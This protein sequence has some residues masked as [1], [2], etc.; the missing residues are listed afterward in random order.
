MSSQY[1]QRLATL[2]QPKIQ[3]TLADIGRGIEKECLRVTP[4]GRLSERP[5]PLELGAALTHEAITTDYSEAL[6]EFI[7]PVYH[8]VDSALA[9][10]ERLHQYTYQVL[11]EEGE[12]LWVASMPCVL[13]GDDSI[14]IGQ[15]GSSNN[16]KMK[17]VYRQGLAHRYGKAMQ[18]IAGIHYNFS[19]PDSF[20]LA[21]QEAEGDKRTLQAFKDANYLRIIRNFHRY[22]WLL[23]YLFGAS[24]ALCKS[25]VGGVAGSL[26]E[27]NQGTFYAPFG[28]SLRM[29]D[30]GYQSSAQEDLTVSYNT[31]EDYIRPLHQALTTPHLEYQAIGVVGDDGEYRQLSTHLLQIENEFYSSIRPKRVTK[32]GE[33]PIN[34]LYERGIEYIEVRCLDLDP[35]SP[36]GMDSAQL[37]FIDQ[38]LLACLLGSDAEMS[39][40]EFHTSAANLK[41]VVNE[42]RRPGLQLNF[43][44]ECKVLTDWGLEMLDKMAGIAEQFDQVFDGDDYRQALQ[45]Q[46]EKLEDPEKTP[47]ARI[48]ADMTKAGVGY[49]HF[50]MDQSKR[51]QQLYL[52]QPMAAKDADLCARQATQSIERLQTVESEQELPFKDFLSDYYR[53]YDSLADI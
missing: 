44:G 36:L 49:F 6:L 12:L 50:A 23:V 22:S 27:F 38:F 10:L 42:G 20:W 8:D 25:F 17:T 53:Q 11:Q 39:E 15:Y 5:H 34:A 37:K 4:Q 26:E 16:G 21:L 45:Q 46:R 43:C 9:D 41:L 48:L 14:P 30:L 13:K 32:P 2:A 28:T 51:Q 52:Q 29:G 1:Q 47:S 24:P 31:L 33:T 40:R 35:Y 18:T 3:Q 7:T 19:L